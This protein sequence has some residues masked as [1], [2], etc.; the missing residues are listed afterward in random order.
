VLQAGASLCI[1]LAAA[2]TASIPL[3]PTAA[4]VAAARCSFGEAGPSAGVV[5]ADGAVTLTL[6]SSGFPKKVAS[7]SSSPVLPTVWSI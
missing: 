2:F 6:L 7:P 1:L 5:F 3:F 4:V